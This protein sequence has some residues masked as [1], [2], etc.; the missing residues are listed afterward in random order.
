[1]PGTGSYQFS[2]HSN[3]RAFPTLNGAFLSSTVTTDEKQSASVFLKF[4]RVRLFRDVDRYARAQSVDGAVHVVAKLQGQL[5]HPWRQ[6][7]VNF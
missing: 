6:L 7:H 2:F 3:V 4:L 1:M 5:V